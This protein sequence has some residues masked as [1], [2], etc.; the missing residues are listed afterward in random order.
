MIGR[1]A[2]SNPWIFRQIAQYTAAKEASGV[3]TYDQPTD[4]D[5]YHMIR[6]Y[7]G[8]L[9]REIE[10]EEAAEAARAAAI[11]ASGQT[12]R[13]QRH[14][15]CV[16]K[17]KQFASWFTHGVPGGGALRKQ[18]FES[19]HGPAVLDAIE[20]FFAARATAPETEDAVAD[21]DETMLASAAAYCD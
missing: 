3:G 21:V 20:A 4:Q 5:R 7:F 18:I 19:K 16:G 12:A 15:D 17:M 2:P 10:I 9:V 1:A 14:R 8:M 6:D 13:D 11:T